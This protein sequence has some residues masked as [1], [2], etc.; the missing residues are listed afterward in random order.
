MCKVDPW[1]VPGNTD[2][3]RGPATARTDECQAMPKQCSGRW[4][5]AFLQGIW[6]FG[7]TRKRVPQWAAPNKNTGHWVSNELSWETT[8]HPCC[9]NSTLEELNTSC[10]TPLG[11]NSW[12][13][14]PGFLWTLSHVLFSF[15]D[16]TL[17][18]FN[19][20]KSQPGIKLHIQS[21][22]IPSGES[23]NMAVVLQTHNT[24]NKSKFVD[25]V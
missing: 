21:P 24:T 9:R 7:T 11:E 1:L 15:A 2:L 6:N 23:P 20:N 13:L 25:T 18:H 4:T 3:G 10:A 17:Y 16:F 8:F 19:H 12:K 5:S 22:V 14:V